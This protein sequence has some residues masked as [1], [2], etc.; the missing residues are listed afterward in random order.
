MRKLRCGSR[1]KRTFLQKM[2]TILFLGA[3]S[4][5]R[6]DRLVQRVRERMPFLRIRRKGQ[7]RHR[8]L[9]HNRAG[10]ERVRKKRPFFLSQE[11]PCFGRSAARKSL[12]GRKPS[13]LDLRGY[14]V[15][16]ARNHSGTCKMR[17]R[18]IRA[19]DFCL[20]SKLKLLRQFMEKVL[21][22]NRDF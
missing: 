3:V 22:Q 8:V 7:G 4:R 14:G 12:R 9:R 20:G 10:A 11:A 21:D 6:K 1:A 2:W 16:P 19:E 18:L 13:V 17:T 5:L 15:C